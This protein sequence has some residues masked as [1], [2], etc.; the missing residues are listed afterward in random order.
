[1]QPFDQVQLIGSTVYFVFSLLFLWLSR[2]PRTPAGPG[3]WSAAIFSA[4]LSRLSLLLLPSLASPQL[5][6]AAYGALT[7]LEK[8]FLVTGAL[9][10]F[11]LDRQLPLIRWPVLLALLWLVLAR[12]LGLAPQEQALGVGAF[13]A[14]A[15]FLLAWFSVRQRH[16]LAGPMLLFTALFS[17][18]LGLHWLSYP[19]LRFD[20]AWGTWGFLAGSALNLLLYL[21][22]LAL[23]LQRFEKRLLDAEQKALDMAYHDPLTGLNNQRY[24]TLLFDQALL[25]ATRPHQFLAVLYIDLDNFKPINDNA[26]HKVGDAVLKEV[27]KRLLEHCR[28][29][30][31]CAR[32]GGDEFVVLATQL[33]SEPQIH[34]VAD[35]LL[36]QLSAPVL[37]GGKAY[38]LGASIGISLYPQHGDQLQ[39]LMD[40]ADAAMYQI[41]KSGKS[42]YRLFEA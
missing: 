8:L 7:M 1:M 16:F 42:G 35:K 36:K 15:L 28:S 34:K 6:E 25:L 19:L 39:Q 20:T 37:V 26:G 24:M 11:G 5:A 21:T 9:K 4:L 17:G 27:A 12:L 32:I 33:D 3:W 41:K 38:Q 22:L 29:T 18:L 2:V 14:Y 30:D 10:C 31:I 23:I 40:R 13:H